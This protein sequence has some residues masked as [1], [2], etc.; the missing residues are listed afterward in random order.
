MPDHWRAFRYFFT[1]YFLRAPLAP[2]LTDLNSMSKSERP[3]K[4]GG[5]TICLVMR[6]TRRT[7]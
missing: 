4:P 1:I 2:T 3:L 6:A 7:P 5:A